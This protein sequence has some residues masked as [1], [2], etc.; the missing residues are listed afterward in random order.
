MAAFI[1]IFFDS[2]IW[3]VLP[4]LVTFAAYVL[5]RKREK[6][7]HHSTIEASVREMRQYLSTLGEKKPRE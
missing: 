7:G 3:L 6:E 2:L 4:F 1:K 5:M